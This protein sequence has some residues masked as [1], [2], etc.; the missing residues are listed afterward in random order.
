MLHIS[1]PGK[2]FIS[3]EWSILEKGNICLVAAVNRR[4]HCQIDGLNGEEGKM[5]VYFSLKDF[6]INVMGDFD[7]TKLNFVA[8]TDEEKK[9]L[10]FAKEAV[11]ISL[12]YLNENSVKLR[13]FRLTSWGEDTNLE[14]D[15]K[16]TKVGFGSSAAA[17]VA[18]VAAVL[19]FHVQELDKET[20]YK[21]SMI[22]HYFAQGKIGS[23]FDVAASTYGGV[24]SYIAPDTEWLSVEIGK[25]E[26]IRDIVESEWPLLEI[27][28]Q[29]IP[30]N[31][32]LLVAWTKSSADTKEMIKNVKEWAKM[33]GEKYRE[34]MS[35]IGNAA[36]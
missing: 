13:S 6:G 8:L 11:E 28:E 17:V 24:F 25:G 29:Q 36:I 15:G 20:I 33:N 3:G 34:C 7:G 12:R 30:E 16:L 1:A 31:L 26:K 32:H 35:A 22:V 27:E 10:Q 21:L 18:I 14:V 19:R 4:V 2:L 9:K 23:G 5:Q